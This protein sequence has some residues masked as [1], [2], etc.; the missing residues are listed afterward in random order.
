[1]DKTPK[2]WNWFEPPAPESVRNEDLL[3]AFER[4]FGG[5]DGALVMN[6]LRALTLDRALGAD[7]PSPALRHL[8]GQRQLVVYIANLADRERRE[9]QA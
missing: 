5:E 7:A 9:M 8:E 4:C 6:H 2:G 3:R 1:M